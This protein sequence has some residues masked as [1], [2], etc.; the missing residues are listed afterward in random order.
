MN[1][2]DAIMWALVGLLGAYGLGF[3]RG[4]RRRRATENEGE[5]AVCTALA[6]AFPGTDVHVMHN[7]TLPDGQGTT[8]IDHVVLSRG[9]IFVIETKHY[10]SV[11]TG[12]ADTGQWEHRYGMRTRPR[13]SPLRQNYKHVKVIERLLSSVPAAHIHNVVV[14][15]GT[16]SFERDGRDCAFPSGVFNMSGI[17]RHIK[18]HSDPV[19]SMQQVHACVGCLE[20]TRR[21]LTRQTDV[22]HQAYLNRKF[23]EVRN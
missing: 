14:L 8:Q 17:V 11:I 2:P 3:W 12:D 16:A 18:Q 10:S 19:L 9:G 5:G 22:E 23:G 1:A 15:T 7:L 21:L 13:Q 6:R 4:R 20:C